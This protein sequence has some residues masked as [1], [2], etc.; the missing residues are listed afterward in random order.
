MKREHDKLYLNE[1]TSNVK[2]S[3]IAV[4]N[5]I[6]CKFSGSI[7]DVGCAVGAFPAYLKARFPE[8]KITGIEYVDTLL[9]RAKE[10][11]SN[12]DFLYGDLLNKDSVNEKFDLITMLGVLCIFDNYEDAIANA[13]SWLNPKG[14]IIMHNMINEHEIDIFIKYS[15]S[16]DSYNVNELESGWN[17]I[18]EKSLSLVCQKYSA[19]LVEIKPF[20]IGVDIKPNRDDVMRSWTELDRNGN[21]QI[22]NALHIRQPQKI[23]IIEKI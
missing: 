17:V 6:D 9:N 10:N 13:I 4:A 22:Y 1:D 11:F 18:S 21:R 5:E 14:K 8:A 12:I 20:K 15:R 7:A 16:S 3:F 19:K 23:A 2:D